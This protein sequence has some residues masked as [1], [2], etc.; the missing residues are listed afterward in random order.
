MS[1]GKCP[2]CGK[3]IGH[4][5]DCIHH[6]ENEDRM[7]AMILFGPYPVKR[8]LAEAVRK[9]APTD[10]EE[11]Y[12]LL[13]VWEQIDRERHADGFCDD[14]TCDSCGRRGMGDDW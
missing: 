13:G 9:K 1:D 10:S 6:E 3:G 8:D 2:E 4:F 11:H 12:R 14:P 7:K 5:L